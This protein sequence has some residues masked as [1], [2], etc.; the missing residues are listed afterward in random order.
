MNPVTRYDLEEKLMQSNNIVEDL[1]TLA[2]YIL[3]NQHSSDDADFVANALNG[4]ACLQ[5]ARNAATWDV[6]I[7]V[8]K[9]DQYSDLYQNEDDNEEEYENRTSTK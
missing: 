7:R 5:E 1:K 9:L 3:E 6:F 4:L 8:F 2:S